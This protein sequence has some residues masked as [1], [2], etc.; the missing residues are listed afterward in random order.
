MAWSNIFLQ[1]ITE[2]GP[3]IG[4]GLLEGW[5]TSI[6]LESF[7]W[8]CEY[9]QSHEKEASGFGAA[10]ASALSSALGLVEKNFKMKPLTIKKRFDIASSQIHFC[11][12]RNLKVFSASISV[13]YIRHGGQAIHRPG[14]TLIAT[15]G[16]FNKVDLEMVQRGHA[17]E[18][19]EVVELEFKSIV[20]TYLK[21]VGKETMPTIPFTYTAPS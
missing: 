21:R 7:D 3:V 2:T 9:K 1:L 13:L 6:E 12:D 17:V 8:G 19:M 15:D 10:A 4:E 20:V 18:V 11:V 16:Y 5:E 14:F